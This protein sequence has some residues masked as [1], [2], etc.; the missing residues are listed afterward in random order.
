MNRAQQWDAALLIDEANAYVHTRGIDL[1]QNAIVGVFLRLME[2][3]KGIL[4]LTT[5]KTNESKEGSFDI[6]DA[7]LSRCDLVIH[8]EI[9][10]VKGRAQIWRD[11]REVRKITEQELPNSV[12]MELAQRFE[13]SGRSIR[14]LLG[15][16]ARYARHSK[17][18]M[19]YQ[20]FES[21]AEFIP[22]TRSEKIIDKKEPV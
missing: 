8:Y 7:I 12:I 18:V 11:Q 14:K 21:V 15:L 13:V 6:D 5:N 4:I 16:T 1:R 9:P 2:S 3:Y 19:D 22:K 10:P 17:L 20:L